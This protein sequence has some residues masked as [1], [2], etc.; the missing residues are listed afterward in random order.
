MFDTQHKSA[1]QYQGCPPAS[2][3]GAKADLAPIVS[4]GGQWAS[5][6][7]IGIGGVARPGVALGRSVRQHRGGMDLTQHLLPNRRISS[8]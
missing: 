7:G 8:S 2:R 6:G 1:A 5:K 3:L 4:I